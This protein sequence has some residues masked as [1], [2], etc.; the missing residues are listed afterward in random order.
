[1]SSSGL[2][3]V[4]IHLQQHLIQWLAGL[5]CVGC[6]GVFVSTTMMASDES[7]DAQRIQETEKALEAVMMAGDIQ[8]K[9]FSDES[10]VRNVIYAVKTS[11]PPETTLE[12]SGLVNAPYVLKLP[13]EKRTAYFSLSSGGDVTL[14]GIKGHWTEYRVVSGQLKR[15]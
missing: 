13:A 5:L 11:L 8:I 6:L 2:S 12:P 10:Q 3:H 14:E 4:Q 7:V 9:Q 15:I 1:V